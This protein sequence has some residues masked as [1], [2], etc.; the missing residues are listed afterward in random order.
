MK[1]K[2]KE[3]EKWREKGKKGDGCE[4]KEKK[5]IVVVVCRGW[6]DKSFCSF[7]P[8]YVCII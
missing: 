2:R 6:H 4:K 7:S 5:V 3:I 1:E 8:L